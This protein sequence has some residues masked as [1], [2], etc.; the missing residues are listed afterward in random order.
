MHSLALVG[1]AGVMLG[2]GELTGSAICAAV[3][4]RKPHM[5]RGKIVTGGILANYVAYLF[6]YLNIPTEAV[7]GPTDSVGVIDPPK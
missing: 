2:V 6:I 4:I 5:S 3:N 1:I 7:L